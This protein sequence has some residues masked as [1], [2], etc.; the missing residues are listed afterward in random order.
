MQPIGIGAIKSTT[1]I[2]ELFCF[3]FENSPINRAHRKGNE[4]SKLNKTW[5]LPSRSLQSRRK[6]LSAGKST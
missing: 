1:N 6:K 4:D 5:Y 3:V 2:Q